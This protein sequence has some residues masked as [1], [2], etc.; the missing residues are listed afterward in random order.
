MFYEVNLNPSI[1][2]DG[3]DN[4]NKAISRRRN[5]NER[6]LC[7]L[8]NLQY[9]YARLFIINVD[10]SLNKQQLTVTCLTPVELCFIVRHTIDTT[11]KDLFGH[12][13]GLSVLYYDL[14]FCQS[15]NI[16]NDKSNEKLFT[17]SWSILLA[18]PLNNAEKIIAAL[19][20]MTN[21]LGGQEFINAT[22]E[23]THL[24]SDSLKFY[25]DIISTSDSL[26]NLQ[27]IPLYKLKR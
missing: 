14:L 25:A 8:D 16:D 26:F 23:S 21:D 4:T 18:V 7:S 1:A 22:I 19:S 11:I 6:R 17:L 12:F 24:K 13:S 20:F 3:D 10:D 15:D 5:Q 27:C 9:I 2:T